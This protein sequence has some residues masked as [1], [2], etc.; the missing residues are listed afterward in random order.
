MSSIILNY[1]CLNINLTFNTF[2]SLFRRH[3][4]VAAN[5]QPR[6]YP[7]FIG[8]QECQLTATTFLFTENISAPLG[9]ELIN[10]VPVFESSG[11]STIPSR[12]LML[13][14]KTKGKMYIIFFISLPIILD[15]NI[16]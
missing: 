8:G 5:R 16:Q 2:N 11:K 7:P 9:E 10:N 13:K 12:Q 1:F 3:N 15:G 6:I 4:A 14:I